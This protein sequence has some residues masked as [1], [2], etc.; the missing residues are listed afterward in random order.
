[1]SSSITVSLEIASDIPRLRTLVSDA[2]PLLLNL[3]PSLGADF[4]TRYISIGDVKLSRWTD[5]VID[6]NRD[7]VLPFTVVDA[8]ISGTGANTTT[9]T[10]GTRTWADLSVERV[11][12]ANAETAYSL[13]SKAEAGTPG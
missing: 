6:D 11:T 12:W 13:W 2:S 10:A 1:M 7:V 4:P 5:V 9:G 3:S 8:P